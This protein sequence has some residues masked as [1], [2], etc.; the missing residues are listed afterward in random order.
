MLFYLFLLFT[1][2]PLIELAML[3]WIGA[4]TV[5]WVPIVFILFTGFAGA[6]LAR[7]QGWRAIVR[8]QYELRA[9][10]IPADA[11]MDGF[12]VLVAAILLITPG[13]LTD[14]AGFA[15]LLPPVRSLVKR[16]VIRALRRR[17]EVKTAH[18]RSAF[19]S[20]GRDAN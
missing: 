11:M 12:L 1:I 2:V 6:V 19:A 4:E 20:A 13:V 8:I 9:G 7:W 14:V 15:L 10:R 5:W 16:I 17:V 18:L 3:V